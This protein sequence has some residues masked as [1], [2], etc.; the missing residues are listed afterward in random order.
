MSRPRRLSPRYP[1]NQAARIRGPGGAERI[2]PMRDI[3]RGGVFLTTCEPLEIFAE[4]EVLLALRGGAPTAVPA[5]VVHIVSAAKAE[6]VGIPAGM[7]L[8]F[9]ATSESHRGAIEALIEDARRAFED[10]RTPRRTPAG[11]GARPRDPMLAYVLEAVDGQTSP[12]ELAA[13]L[14]LEL[15]VAEAILRKLE[16]AGLVE[17]PQPAVPEARTGP[18]A[19]DAPEGPPA[20]VPE[21]SAVREGAHPGGAGQVAPAQP[22]PPAPPAT[23]GP[24]VQASER[25]LVQ[26]A[27]ARLNALPAQNHYQVLGVEQDGPAHVIR[28]A[29]VTLSRR[30]QP[31]A[32]LASLPPEALT[33][34]E[35]LFGLLKEAYGVLGRP[36]SRREYDDYLNRQFRLQSEPPGEDSRQ[37]T[38]A[39]G[40]QPLP[41]S[42]VTRSNPPPSPTG[43][44]T[45]QPRSASVAKT[46]KA[47]GRAA[48]ESLRR[49]LGGATRSPL[50][51]PAPTVS[52]PERCLAEA[53][54]AQ[55]DG[56]TDDSLKSLKLL[57]AMDLEATKREE[58]RELRAQI[59]R[60]LAF[61]L[62]KKALYEEK[63]QKWAQA[64]V[65]WRKVCEGR[66]EDDNAWLRAARAC[67]EAGKDLRTAAKL[68]QQA[69]ALAPRNADAHRVLGHIWLAAGMN[70]NARKSLER[71]VALSH[72]DSKTNRILRELGSRRS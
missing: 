23:E 31:D 48:A 60:S 50:R 26:D 56:R 3:S 17:L 42:P 58:V 40:S 7:G 65:T 39:A 71:A 30:F 2:F 44:G 13:R 35:A 59:Y 27:R 14:S 67:L 64:A 34:L 52:L 19:P 61:E 18:D 8:Q 54:A 69:I 63:H 45:G 70:E 10:S 33:E 38:G 22:A 16:D 4:V 43:T 28:D 49:T 15:E 47:R 66:P 9:E 6:Q 46:R 36:A 51:G 24:P 1:T 72:P 41:V 12:E 32:H 5:R 68:A 62:E 29:F 55:A 37:P 57:L 53:R 21:A 20:P 11:D 25:Q